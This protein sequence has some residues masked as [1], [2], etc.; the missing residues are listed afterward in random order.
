MQEREVL[1]RLAETGALLEGHFLLRSGL[2]SN[3]YFQAAQ[4]L[5]HTRIAAELCA[6]LAARFSRNQVETVISPAVGGIVVG[7]EVGRA[8]GVRAIF[9]EKDGD[10]NL[11][12]RRGFTLAPGEKV[13]VAEDVVTRGGRVQQTIDLVRTAGAEVVGVAVLVDRS[14]GA[15]AFGAVPVESL[16]KLELATYKPEECPM[17][18]EGQGIDKPGS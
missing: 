10:G 11:V 16:L 7:Q 5:Q 18:R 12:L 6:A 14:G 3:R 2:H 17:C 13:L 15:A 4:V 8:L 9:A 1:K